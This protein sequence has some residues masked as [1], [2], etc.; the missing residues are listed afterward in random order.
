MAGQSKSSLVVRIA[1]GKLGELANALDGGLDAFLLNLV[2]EGADCMP[3]QLL[4][5][6]AY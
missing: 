2:Q 4:F 3:C 5:G 1:G 6:L